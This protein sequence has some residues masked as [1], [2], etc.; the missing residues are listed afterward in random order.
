VTCYHALVDGN[1]R[2]GLLAMTVFLRI[3]GFELGRDD[4]E[5]FDLTMAVAAGELDAEGI[6]LRLGLVPHVPVSGS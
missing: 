1:K 5:A 3:N 2:L 6:E 4:D